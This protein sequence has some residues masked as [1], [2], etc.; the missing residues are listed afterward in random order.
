L[1]D[2]APPFFDVRARWRAG[3][4]ALALASALGLAA[5][6]RPFERS[7]GPPWLRLGLVLALGLGLI[8]TAFLA[9]LRGRGPQEQLAFYSYLTLALDALTQTLTPAGWPA[10]PLMTLL[11]A[12]VAVA[13]RLPLAFGI[14]SLA[15]LLAAADAGWRLDWRTGAATAAGYLA[16]VFAVNRALLGEKRRL[17]RTVDE[18]A[19]LKYGIGQLEDREVRDATGPVTAVKKATQDARRARQ[20]ERS[21]QLDEELGKLVSL[22][23]HATRAHSVS[24]FEID[25]GR[26]LAFVRAASGP[27]TLLRDASVSLGDDPF[28]FVLERRATFYATDFKRLLWALPWYRGEVKIGSLIAVPVR[29]G[30]VVVAVLIADQVEIQAFTGA[31]PELLSAFADLIA[32]ALVRARVLQSSEDLT[33]AFKAAQD[34]SNRVAAQKDAYHV[35]SLLLVSAQQIASPEMAAV[36]LT[37]AGSTRYVVKV[38]EGWARD[39]VGREVALDEKTWAAWVVRSKEEPHLDGRFAQQQERMPI[40]VLDEPAS[41]PEALL[42]VPLRERNGS[43]GAL[44]LTGSEEAFGAVTREVL[45]VIANQAAAVIGTL[46]AIENLKQVAVRDGLT[47]LFNR[48]AFQEL[49][50]ST[51]H[52]N[53]RQA[54][55]FSLVLLDIDHFKKLNDTHGHPA[56]DEALRQVA[57][58]L[59]RQCRGGDE[60]ARYGGE[61]FAVVLA[62]GDKEAALQAA[63]RLRRELQK[64]TLRLAGGSIQLTASFGVA[65]WPGDGRTP[66]ALLAAA[67]KALYA[68]KQAGRNRVMA[69]SATS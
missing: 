5:L 66:D 38:A 51:V 24:Y 39:F 14:A 54:G 61:E 30:D 62:S 20:A 23:R 35:S 2:G 12:G 45:R 46:R 18:L 36:V 27:D 37:D 13:E 64:T 56:G 53:E 7:L 60:A 63:E 9:S 40:L 28:S 22:V 31:E 49:L 17:S 34:L 11:L 50:Q 15:G 52:R 1:G 3:S 10:W 65:V 29:T 4:V 44:I 43:V 57:A 33:V 6:L 59:K 16:L 48:R 26:E 32:D 55:G 8:V 21:G 42:A 25:R 69:A 68:A 19:R 41:T 47:G 58:V 67:D